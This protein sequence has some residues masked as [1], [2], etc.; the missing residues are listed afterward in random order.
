MKKFLVILTVFFV[1]IIGVISFVLFSATGLGLVFRVVSSLTDG[2]VT[3]EDYDGSIAGGWRLAG[4]NIQTEGAH[5]FIRETGVDWQLSKI[6]R[7]NVHATAISIK[8]LEVSIQEPSEEPQT[9]TVAPFELPVVAIPI[10]ILVDRLNIDGGIVKNSG[11]DTPLFVLEKLALRIQASADQ[12]V[13]EELKVISPEI[14]TTVSGTL[15]FAKDWPVAF[16]G[17]WEADIPGYTAASGTMKL[18]GTVNSPLFNVSASRPYQLQVDGTLSNVFEELSWQISGSAEKV[19]SQEISPEWPLLGVDITVESAGSIDDYHGRVTAMIEVDENIRPDIDILFSGNRFNLSIEPATL[20][21]GSGEANVEA[22]VGWQNTL[23]WQVNGLVNDFDLSP[24]VPSL[25]P[26]LS[27]SLSSKGSYGDT[28]SYHLEISDLVGTIDGL[29]TDIHG[30]LT[31]EGNESGL[32]LLSSDFAVAEGH[33]ELAGQLN[34]Q[35][36]LSWQFQG[37][38]DDIDLSALDPVLAASLSMSIDS[39]GSYADTLRY[40]LEVHDIVGSIDRLSHDVHGGIILAGNEYGLEILSSD[41]AL[42]DGHIGLAGEVGWREGVTWQ[43]RISLD[44][45]DPSV[46]EPTIVGSINATLNSHGVLSESGVSGGIE[47]SD[48]NGMLAG[49]ALSGG[50]IVDYDNGNIE[51]QNLQLKNGGNNFEVDGAIA[52]TLDLV[53]SLDGTELNRVVPALHGNLRAHGTVA[54]SKTFPELVLEASGEALSY[55]DY[56]IGNFVSDVSVVTTK[57][58]SVKVAVDAGDIRAAGQNISRAAAA[59]NGSMEDH[60]IVINIDSEQGA[61][62]FSADGLLEGKKRWH[63]QIQ[64]IRLDHPRYGVFQNSDTI[65]LQISEQSADIGNFC[66]GAEFIEFCGEGSWNAPVTWAFE[67]EKIKVDLSLLNDWSIMNS[68]VSGV[69]NGTAQGAGEGTR[70]TTLAAGFTLDELI[71]GLEENEYYQELKWL[72][73]AFSIKL[74]D[75]LLRSELSSR[76][77]D[78]S[79]VKGV[80]T[81]DEFADVTAPLADLGLAG[82]LKAEINDLTPLKLL[83]GGYLEPKGRLFADL[84][85]T[86]SIGDPGVGGDLVLD[87]G[88]IHIPDLNITPNNISGSVKGRGKSVLVSLEATSGEG[89]ASAEGEFDFENERWAGV[90]KIIGENVDLVQQK[91]VQITADSDLVLTLGPD[92]GRLEGTLV[93]PKALIQPEEMTGSVSESDDVIMMGEQESSGSWPFNMAIK[94]ELGEDVLVD[95]YGLTGN[96]KGS[97]DLA[98]TK[99]TF[100]AGKGELYLDNGLFSLYERE[101]KISRGRVLFYGGPVDNPG[102]DVS[103]RKTIV[104]DELGSED[105]VVGVNIIGSVDDFEMELFSIP[106]MDDADIVSYIIAGSSL[107]SSGDSE[108]GAIGA[109]LNAITMSRGNKVLGNIGDVFAVDDLKV[110]GSGSDDT[111][112]VVG[113]KLLDELYIS[114]DFNL[115]KNAGFFRIRYDFGKGFSVESKNSVESNGVNLLYSF[116]R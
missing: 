3:I 21:L 25:A 116:E 5:V 80:L 39:E 46:I 9:E 24:F 85:I 71:L 111:S 57:G 47:L 30:G 100:L 56:S 76:F 44:T 11:S 22:S 66:I 77:V 19:N 90:L 61:L 26:S 103:A 79:F 15:T 102:L 32:E 27:G 92:G 84:E 105:I 101:L 33:I 108:S 4:L 37:Q 35:N 93:I 20:M 16:Q 89:T 55:G 14:D 1:I 95:G 28:L 64:T 65:K 31:L 74:D 41:F 81:I 78:D 29:R 88:E 106:S 45:F 53:F 54:G 86:G 50:G 82:S 6:L 18:M 48:V 34:W 62:E 12:L 49:Y 113:K 114:Y 115:Y 63:G 36:N 97:L 96:L 107:S 112:L 75:Q 10:S 68:A 51:I 52:D 17:I 94:I 42:G 72:D 98:N 91:E 67:A 70:L 60:Q 23:S 40:R 99:S 73:S 69:I 7:G 110:K 59:L 43:S 2:A 83:T 38:V 87:G 109:A 58:G 13:V 8:E 104:A